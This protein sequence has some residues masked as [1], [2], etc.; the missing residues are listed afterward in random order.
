MT[1]MVEMMDDWCS[2]GRKMVPRMVDVLLLV[3]LEDDGHWMMGLCWMGQF[4]LV[5]V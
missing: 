2:G 5:D 3:V 1:D 4:V